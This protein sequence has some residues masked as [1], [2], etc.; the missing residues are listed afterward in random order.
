MA[1]RIL[2][3]KPQNIAESKYSE[4]KKL[5]HLTTSTCKQYVDLNNLLF[6]NQF[7]FRKGYSTY[8]AVL[9]YCIQNCLDGKECMFMPIFM[10]SPR[11]LTR[12]AI[13]H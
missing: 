12:S 9:N 11:F 1:T 6:K 4:Y 2:N 8:N 7:G 10:F 3:S 5:I 13:M